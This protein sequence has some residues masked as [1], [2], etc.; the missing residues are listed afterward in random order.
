ML[1]ASIWISA[2]QTTC[3]WGSRVL[4]TW[5]MCVSFILT[6][7]FCWMSPSIGHLKHPCE[8]QPYKLLLLNEPEYW[9]LE[10]SV[11]VSALQTTSVEWARVLDT[12]SIRV[13]F[14]LT[15]YFCWMSLSI[16]HLK[17][18]CEFQPYKLLL[19]NEPEYWTLEASVWVSVLQTT[20]VEWARVLDTWSIR[21]S[22]SLTNY[23]CWMSL[24]IGHLKH[25]CEFQPYKL[26]L[27]NELEYWILEASVWV[28]A[29]Q[30]TSVEW[31]WVLDTWSIRVSFSLTNY[32]CWMSSSIGHLKHPC[33]F[34]PYKLLLLNELEYWTLEASVWVSALQTT[35]VE[36]ARVLDTWSIRVSFSLTN[37]FCWMSLSIG[38]LKHPCEF[39]PY[40]LLLLNE[41]EYWT[42]EASVWVSALQTTS[43]EWAWVLDT[44]SIRVSF[45][46]LI[47]TRTALV[48]SLPW[49]Y[50]STSFLLLSSVLPR[51][52]S[53]PFLSFSSPGA[54]RVLLGYE[55]EVC[56]EE[57]FH[58]YKFQV[59]VLFVVFTM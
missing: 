26:L 50:Y 3:V 10:A 1:A 15:N 29:L 33:E 45:S 32:F 36:W 57:T 30:T 34:Q 20:S 46:I 40:K 6:N 41:P 5:S 8:F 18:P 31:A 9:T 55:V 7:Y 35:S 48:W 58:W 43:V 27:L 39:Q 12:W 49:S 4:D 22:F 56:A 37:Y 23:F 17:H 53:P 44:W 42:L 25:P 21:V 28:S 52:F 19:L 51:L 11:W 54:D 2:L 14:S 24:S 59:V 16:G 13:S 47:S 38:H